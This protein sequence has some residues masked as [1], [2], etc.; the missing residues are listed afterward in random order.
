MGGSIDFVD[1]KFLVYRCPNGKPTCSPVIGQNC[2]FLRFTKFG[3][4]QMCV[5]C[6]EDLERDA[7]GFGYIRPVAKCPFWKDEIGDGF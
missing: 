3:N 4:S 1:L 2:E 6:D 7:D 5:F